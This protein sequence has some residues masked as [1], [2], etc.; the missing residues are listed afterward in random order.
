MSTLSFP[1]ISK[2]LAACALAL[3]A[4]AWSQ[5]WDV[6]RSHAPETTILD[7]MATEGTWISLD[8]SPDGQTIVFDLLGHIYQMPVRGGDATALTTG[9]SWNMFPQYS[10]D[11]TQIAFTSDRSGSDDLWV[12]DRATGDLENVSKSDLVVFRGTWSADGRHLYAAVLTDGSR[13]KAYQFHVRGSK[14]E[15]LDLGVFRPANVFRE[16][17]ARQKLFYE[18]NDGDLYASGAQIK[19][20][21]LRTGTVE[22][23]LDRPGGAMNPAL[24]PD[25]RYLAYVHRDDLQSQLIIHDLETRQ[26]RVLVPLDRDRQAYKVYHHGSY[27]TMAWHPSGA[28]V[29]VA[30]GGKI[31]AVNVES[32]DIRTIPFRARVHRELDKTILFPVPIPEGPTQT[33]AHRWAQR[34]D[35]GILFE[36]L[37][38]LYL[39]SGNE[40]R[41]LTRSAAHETSPAYHPS[42]RTLYYASWSDDEMGAIYALPLPEGR[43]RKLTSTPTQYGALSVSPDGRSVAFVRGA[44]ALRMGG[45]LEGQTEFA[46]VV[47]GPD[48]KEQK[49]TDVAWSANRRARYPPMTSF[50]PHGDRVYFDEFVGDTLMLKKIRLDGLDEMTLYRFPHAVGVAVSPDA[51]WIAF[52]EYSRTYVTPFDFVGKTLMVS[53]EDKQGFRQ[54]V[55]AEADGLFISWAAGSDTLYWSRGS[56]FYEKSLND[57]LAGGSTA[58]GTDVSL[59]FEVEVPSSTVAFR[60]VR[61][62]TMNA[63]RDVME[64]ATLLVRRNRIEAIGPA[65]PIPS[66]A[67]VYDLPGHT[68]MPGIVDVHAHYNSSISALNVVQQRIARLHAALAHGVTTMYEVAGSN[69]KDAWVSDML[70][71]GSMTGP[72][73]FTVGSLIYGAREFRPKQYRS[74]QSLDDAREH[75]RF[76]KAHGA[77]ALKDY[78]TRTRKVRHML[79]TAAREEG[80]NLVVEPGGDAQ[81]NLT[82]LID[83]ATGIAHGMGYTPLF[84]DVVRIHAAAETGITP[85]LVVTLD[86][87]SGESFF[88]LS[89]RLWENPKLLNFATRDELIA[90]TRRSTHFWPDDQF[91]PK[92]AA[93]LKRLHD[94]GVRIQLGAHGQMLGLDAHWE[95]ELFTQGGFSP[96]ESIQIATINGARHTGLDHA[97]GSIEMGK[98]ADLVVLRDNPLVNIRNTRSVVYVMK[99]GVVYSGDD[100]A[101]VYPDPRPAARM[102]FQLAR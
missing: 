62:I 3:P 46:L 38:D 86:G 77:T 80:V 70:R 8:V 97:L 28:E 23:Y 20:Y 53:A 14:Q 13:N 63:G 16:H 57:V 102:Y 22:V 30:I 78:L 76:N 17:A 84:E 91:S 48:G 93:N 66:D 15:L 21:D 101:R 88:Y 33:R 50:D 98:L 75:V 71:Q 37:G 11:G 92:L 81:S 12:L 45:R 24:S 82:R 2:T 85:T 29:L 90:R 87:P 54:R 7:Y 83:G 19:T 27:S 55:D 44:G 96:M 18:H 32:R 67:K 1:R 39:K 58:H 99:N 59:P 5:E 43:P 40:V 41:N 35:E 10:P 73:L 95:M 64:N 68:V 61:V 56:E 52:H 51:R 89:E 42:T 9:R 6:E 94:A 72:R 79:A 60:G 65:V 69:R 31:R 100:A 25:G 34:T 4:G 49:V 74:I 36:T 47:I 26:E